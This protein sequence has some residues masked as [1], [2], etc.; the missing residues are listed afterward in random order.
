MF[1]ILKKKRKE[2]YSGFLFDISKYSECRTEF[3][4]AY[5]TEKTNYYIKS[6]I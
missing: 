3:V 4:V 6:A 1:H 2:S 5:D